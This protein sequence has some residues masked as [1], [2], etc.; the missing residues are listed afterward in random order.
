[1]PARKK[2][3]FRRSKF[4]RPTQRS[5]LLR[6][7]KEIFERNEGALT[8]G[9]IIS[10]SKP[11]RSWTTKQLVK[12]VNNNLSI[13][14]EIKRQSSRFERNLRNNNLNRLFSS[15]IAYSRSQAT[16]LVNELISRSSS[17]IPGRD[18]LYYTFTF[19]GNTRPI[20]ESTK[21]FFIDFLSRNGMA[22]ER[23]AEQY[24]SDPM[25]QFDLY[26]LGDIQ[27]NELN[28]PEE[29]PRRTLQVSV[30]FFPYLN[31][32]EEYIDLQRYGIYSTAQTQENCVIHA[33]NELGIDKAVTNALK[34][35][36][37]KDNKT[38]I[39]RSHLPKVAQAI[40]KQIVL[41]YIL[42]SP[43]RIQKR[44][45][46]YGDS[47]HETIELA[48]YLDHLFIMEHTKYT[49]A[50]I[51]NYHEVRDL[52]EWWKIT[53]IRKGKTKNT[54]DRTEA[55]YKPLNSL[56]LILLMHK[57]QIFVKGDMSQNAE[58]EHSI[59]TRDHIYLDNIEN[60][61]RLFKSSE[62]IKKS[63]KRLDRKT[64]KVYY[65]DCESFVSTKKH[66]LYLLGVASE[67]DDNTRIYNVCDYRA[68]EHGNSPQQ[69]L[70]WDFLSYVTRGKKTDG[71]VY[72]HNLKYDL[73]I[74]GKYFRFKDMLQKD[75]QVY[76]V[77]IT[78]GGREIELR[79]S[80][81]LLNWRLA[82]FTK[83][84]GL[85]K[86]FS[87]AEAIAYK[88]YTPE[89]NGQMVKKSLYRS[90]LSNKD[91]LIFDKLMEENNTSS[92]EFNA[93]DY[94]IEYLKLD[95]LVL[96]HGLI[97]FNQI[98]ERITQDK[99]SIYDCRTISSLTDKYF[100]LE[101]AYD[102]VYE[103]TGNLR[104]FI[105]EAIYGGRVHV[106][107]KYEKKVVE[108]RTAD[109]D[110]V[111]LYPSAIKRMCDTAHDGK[112]IPLG[113][114]K[115]FNRNE[116]QSW[117]SKFYSI[118]QVKITKVN[119][120]QQMAMI[121]NRTSDSI[122]YINHPPDNDVIIDCITLQDYIKYHEIEYELID[123]V[124]W[125][126]GGITKFGFLIQNLFNE[127]L[128][129][130][131][132]KQNGLQQILKLMLNSAYGKTIQKPSKVQKKIVN[133][134]KY[135]KDKDTGKWTKETKSN[136]DRY[137][138]NNFKTISNIIQLNKD[139]Y[140]ITQNSADKSYS[141]AQTGTMVLSYSKRIM[142]EI[143]GLANDSDIP[144]M[145]TDTDSIHMPLD[146]V[147]RLEDEFKKIY[148]RELN[149]KQL[150]Q[151]HVDFDL[152]GA[153]S[154]IYS[155]HFIAL[156]KKCYID[157]LECKNQDGTIVKGVHLRLK[158][159]T[160]EGIEHQAKQYNAEDIRD[161]Y[162]KLYKDLAKGTKIEFTLNPFNKEANCE[163]V[164]FEFDKTS[165]DSFQVSTKSEFKRIVAF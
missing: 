142:N 32:E 113:K 5:R 116:L 22:L 95:C 125:D 132:N 145:Y 143:F 155:T 94:Y 25:T 159:V 101:G 6:T 115:R 63:I 105:S 49:T 158:G 148:N 162:Y 68:D 82:D 46:V 42:K 58:T 88:F 79:D 77:K 73:H 53:K 14:N 136:I 144:I 85:D 134:F 160:A 36:V 41:H 87:K 100:C 157:L 107:P 161:G 154:E 92:D 86:K 121:A 109:Y 97:K 33:L 74:I 18:R 163:K 89:R 164:L 57:E 12:F 106:N 21:L 123:G 99:L 62:Q 110:G 67:R 165:K 104:K 50:S 126:E 15:K 59:Y 48:M 51:K 118:L 26:D 34:L 93:T 17:E 129:A 29:Q 7:A 138:I 54:Y 64:T 147:P 11:N 130:K 45:S 75:G 83:N 44:K 84:L 72:F 43:N 56:D 139:Q 114:A 108:G 81:K 38:F 28:D 8:L 3:K 90:Y 10:A 39:K 31:Q 146:D 117:N 103:S 30:G 133:K 47:S 27:L 23:T 91:K 69:L 2:S 127:R 4:K 111:S 150:T 135:T 151:F 13:A 71:L 96:K 52:P 128:K 70:I 9:G 40:K 122:Q 20:K 112:G 140:E 60:E 137:I 37:A 1:M 153:D 55:N 98:V 102:G 16:R 149:G 35:E 65:A 120:H 61:Q 78:Y 131:A 119:K 152:K 156:G 76:S 66:S 19:N 24:G 124:Y 80:Y 141:R